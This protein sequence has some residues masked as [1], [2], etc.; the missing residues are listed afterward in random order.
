[1]PQPSIR[2]HQGLFKIFKDGA[3]SD[4][5][6]LTS[7]TINQDSTFSRSFYVGN[8]IPES[9]QTMEGWS[10]SVEMEVKSAGAEE[11]IDGLV[12]DNLNGIGI[13]DYTFLVTEN[14]ADGTTSSYVYTD[15]VWKYS[16]KAGGLNEKITKTLEFQ[17][18]SRLPV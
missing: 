14:Y 18:S 4:I 1:M 2:G 8:A 3:V 10:G 5:L 6:H 11:F 7:V 9:D 12:N 13:A 16:R 15:C 17:A